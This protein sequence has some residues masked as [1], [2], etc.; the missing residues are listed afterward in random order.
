MTAIAD[1]PQVDLEEQGFSFPL[2][3]GDLADG[4]VEAHDRV[5]RAEAERLAWVAEMIATEAYADVGYLSPIALLVD[6]L[7]ISVGTA[8][9]LIGLARALA[10]MPVVRAA[11]HDGVLDEPRVHLLAAARQANPDLFSEKEEMLVD[12]FAG[13]S[14]KDFAT[15]VDLWRQNTDLDAAEQDAQQLRDRRYLNVSPTL[16]NLVRIDGQL[17]PEAGQTLLTALRSITDPQQLDP[18][19]TR[20]PGQRRAD[21]LTQMCADHLASGKSPISGGFRPQVTVTAS[22]ETL[23]GLLDGTGCETEDCGLLTPGIVRKILCD[24]EVTPVVLGGGSL[25]LDIGRSSRTIPWWIRNLLNLRDK[26][27]VIP[28]CQSRPRYCDAH[29][30]IHWLHGGPTCL[31]NLC[32]LCARHHTMVHDGTITLPDWVLEMA[33]RLPTRE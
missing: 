13:L 2:W 19:D 5:V 16:G 29:H 20:T 6:R 31:E 17:D 21:A 22:Y 4:L 28:G 14:M 10:E 23:L 9:R 7:G 33:D 15:A 1:R 25:P 8:R 12:S 3:S 24:A 30:V 26:G 32:L 27:C 18:T 11:F